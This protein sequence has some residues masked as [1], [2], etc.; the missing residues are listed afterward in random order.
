M[1]ARV[2]VLVR[3]R[4]LARGSIASLTCR[5]QHLG[6]FEAGV[7]SAERFLLGILCR[8]WRLGIAACHAGAVAGTGTGQVVRRVRML[9]LWGCVD[10]TL[11]TA[12]SVTADLALWT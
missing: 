12:D 10:T 9:A 11:H 1:W 2:R 3:V 8:A 5:L 7:I 6:K 4:V